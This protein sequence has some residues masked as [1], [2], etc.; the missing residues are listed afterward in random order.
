MKVIVVEANPVELINLQ[1]SSHTSGL[2]VRHCEVHCEGGE[3]DP[4]LA[5]GTQTFNQ[6][7]NPT[8]DLQS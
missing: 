8:V 2:K 5:S 7:V 4:S 1:I 6:T 3:L